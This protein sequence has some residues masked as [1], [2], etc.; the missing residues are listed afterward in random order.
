MN[1]KMIL[2]Q[3][4]DRKSNNARHLAPTI[5]RWINGQ[6]KP[7]GTNM[8]M[9]YSGVLASHYEGN[10]EA[11]LFDFLGFARPELIGQVFTDGK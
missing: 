1:A 9:L 8:L 11:L 10:Q 2:G 7:N 6:A 5:R 3:K 4:Y